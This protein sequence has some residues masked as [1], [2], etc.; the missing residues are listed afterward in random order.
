MPNPNESYAEMVTRLNDTGEVILGDDCE[1]FN[2]ATGS[3]G[4]F[5]AVF[6]QDWELAD[7]DELGG[8]AAILAAAEEAWEWARVNQYGA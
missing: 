6:T 5:V 8:E 3:D 4:E 7:E 2:V 1:V